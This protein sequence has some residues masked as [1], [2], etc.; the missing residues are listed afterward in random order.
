MDLGVTINQIADSL[1]ASHGIATFLDNPI[2]IALVTTFIIMVLCY[3]AWTNGTKERL[4]LSFY[5]FCTH[6]IILFLY[7]R[8]F[9][10][11]Q[12]ESA[13][14]SEVQYALAQSATLLPQDPVAVIP[15]A[16]M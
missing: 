12:D 9:K 15:P 5:V 1:S 3:F 8:R 13:K 7:H 4:R 2:Y 16:Y 11:C 10:K 14:S 6:L